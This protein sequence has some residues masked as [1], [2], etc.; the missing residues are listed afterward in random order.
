[1]TLSVHLNSAGTGSIVEDISP[2]LVLVDPEL[3]KFARSRLPAPATTT[4]RHRDRDAQDIRP[5]AAIF[6]K[7]PRPHR[8]KQSASRRALIGVAAVTMLVLLLFDLHVEVG[9]RSPSS[10]VSEPPETIIPA[11][12]AQSSTALSTPVRPSPVTPAPAKSSPRN[13]EKQEATAARSFAWAPT[14]GASGYYVEFFRGGTR[15]YAGETTGATVEV[16][17]RWRYLGVARSFRP[18]TYRWYVWPI[19]GELRAVRAAVQTT[20]SIPR[21]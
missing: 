20:V 3:A 15:V 16:P 17:A 1:M 14:E 11:T 2:E 4:H 9:D 10:A 8:I 6:S 12:A 7:T 19:V 21:G 5:V 18:G 13:R